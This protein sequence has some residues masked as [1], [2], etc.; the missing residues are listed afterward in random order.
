M[1]RGHQILTSIFGQTARLWDCDSG[2][3]LSEPLAHPNEVLLNARFTPD[4]HY[5]ALKTKSANVYVWDTPPTVASPPSWLPDL[6]EA[7]AGTR[8]NPAGQIEPV[9]KSEL[10]RLSQSMRSLT[11]TDDCSQWARWF[12]ADRA[13]RSVSPGLPVTV[14]Q[15]VQQWMSEDN[16]NSL[17]RAVLMSPTN[18]LALARLGRAIIRRTSPPDACSLLEADFLSKQ[19]LSL[20]PNLP[21]VVAIRQEIQNN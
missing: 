7:L 14:P 2:L 4:G 8:F 13:T 12:W 9:P 3:P 17:R 16:E 1:P 19:A 10:S 20:D 15:L 18:A 6:A 11:G 5:I 21:E